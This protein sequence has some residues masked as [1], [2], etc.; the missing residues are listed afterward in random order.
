MRNVLS[1][2]M[3]A[4]VVCWSAVAFAQ[5]VDDETVN[6]GP[7]GIATQSSEYNNGQFPASLGI[8]GNL[9]NFTHTGAGQNLPSTWELDLRAEYLISSIVLYNRRGCCPSRFRDL[10]VLVLDGPDGDILFES[11]LLNPENVLGNGE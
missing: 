11:D 5:G 6:V 3:F 10:T 1:G 8:D 7:L 2:L 9:G 4:L